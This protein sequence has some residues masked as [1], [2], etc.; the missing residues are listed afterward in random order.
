MYKK[1]SDYGIVGDLYTIALI[2]LD[3]SELDVPSFYGFSRHIRRTA[4]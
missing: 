1:I 2:G 4:G 3:G